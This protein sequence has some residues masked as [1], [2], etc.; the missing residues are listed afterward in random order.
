MR[1]TCSD[2]LITYKSQKHHELGPQKSYKQFNN[3]ILQHFSKGTASGEMPP[4]RMNTQFPIFLKSDIWYSGCLIL[5][6]CYHEKYGRLSSRPATN[7]VRLTGM[8]SSEALCLLHVSAFS[9]Q[10][11]SNGRREKKETKRNEEK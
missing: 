5:L 9:I 10:H 8:Y 3:T 7:A 6:A 1:I 2:V 11:C 4:R